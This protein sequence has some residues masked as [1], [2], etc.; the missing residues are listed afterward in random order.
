[1]FVEV[2]QGKDVDDMKNVENI[3][4][5]KYIICVKA[6]TQVIRGSILKKSGDR[7]TKLAS[8]IYQLF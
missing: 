6:P 5:V 3:I 7:K 2:S 4:Y 1:M 8:L